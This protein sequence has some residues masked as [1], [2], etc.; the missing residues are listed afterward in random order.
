M[1]IFVSIVTEFG[2]LLSDEETE[3]HCYHNNIAREKHLKEK[4]INTFLT[5]QGVKGRNLTS[6]SRKTNSFL[7]HAVHTRQGHL[8]SY[9][10]SK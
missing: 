7:A 8:E 4:E 10:D 1:W 3:Y 2:K 5:F 9:Q 6:G